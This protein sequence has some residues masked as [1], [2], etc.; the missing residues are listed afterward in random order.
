M[1]KK[2]TSI[3]TDSSLW[4]HFNAWYAKN[5]LSQNDAIEALMAYALKMTSPQIQEMREALRQWRERAD[6]S[7][8]EAPSLAQ[9]SRPSAAIASEIRKT[10]RHRQGQKVR[11]F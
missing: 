8:E 2:K 3:T 4:E 1:N 5:I 6:S 7:A 9:A 11:H 10:K